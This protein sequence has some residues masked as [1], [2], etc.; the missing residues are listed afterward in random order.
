MKKSRPWLDYDDCSLRLVLE[1]ALRLQEKFDL[2]EADVFES[3]PSYLYDCSFW[4]DGLVRYGSWHV[5]FY[6]ARSWGKIERI[7]EDSNCHSGFEHFSRTVGDITLRISGKSGTSEPER[8]CTI[9]EEG[10]VEP[11]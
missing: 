1:D 10:G 7:L 2:G 8:I 4:E 5:R 9:T 11:W 6:E 3:S